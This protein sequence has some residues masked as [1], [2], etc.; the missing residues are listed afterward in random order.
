MPQLQL[1]MAQDS[2]KREEARSL[3]NQGPTKAQKTKQNMRQHAQP[4]RTSQSKHID[5]HL[6]NKGPQDN[7]AKTQ[8]NP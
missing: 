6:N 8:H 7:H 4:K 5:S 3:P 2:Q 1:K